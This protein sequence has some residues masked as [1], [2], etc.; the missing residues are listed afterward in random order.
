MFRFA[1]FDRKFQS[2]FAYP[3]KEEYTG[4]PVSSSAEFD[5]E[6]EM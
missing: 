3:V 4:W 6:A 5:F 2:V 1:L